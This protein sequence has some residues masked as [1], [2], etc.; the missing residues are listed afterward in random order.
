MRNG[1][2]IAT[3]WK[4]PVRLDLSWFII[5]GLVTWSLAGGVLA[6]GLPGAAPGLLW[7]LGAAAGLLFAASVLLHELGHVY[8]ALRNQVPVR[9]VTLFLFG[10]VAEIT[11]DPQTPGA[12]LRIA[13][14][15]PAVSLALAGIFGAA[16]FFTQGWLAEA[17]VPAAWLARINLMLAVFNLIPGFPLDGGRIFRA[18]VWMRTGSL[19]RATRVASTGGQWVG[20]GF[21]GVGLFSLLTGGAFNG[22][23][24]IFIGWFL[25][26]AAASSQAQTSLQEAL[27]GLTVAEVMDRRVDSAAA[28]HTLE[29]VVREH[30]LS[31]SQRVLLVTDSLGNGIRGWVTLEDIV[32]VPRAVWPVVTVGQLMSPRENL[33]VLSPQAELLSALQKMDESSLSQAPVIAENQILGWLSRERIQN[34]LRLRTELGI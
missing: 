16:A 28:H 22:L 31:G 11:R 26:N 25:R 32:R 24:L 8:F 27:R 13:A 2:Q 1:I 18:L 12:E 23:W 9:G 3:I 21:M 33:L 4:V 5:F 7:A 34:Y 17:S 19:A 20:Y 14:A 29:Q 30:V 15:G 6:E 10:G